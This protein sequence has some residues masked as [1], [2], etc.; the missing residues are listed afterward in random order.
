QMTNL[1][2]HEIDIMQ[3]VIGVSGPSAVS[4]S[5]G[6]FAVQDIGETP[7]TQD[8]LFEYPGFTTAYS[9]REASAGRRAGTGLEFFGPK[10]S[11]TISPAGGPE[12]TSVKP[13]PWAEAI[14]E[15]GSSAQQFDLHARNFLD[16][17]K[18]RQRPIADV[19]GGHQTTTAC[20]LANLSLRLGRKLKWDP[21]KEEILGDREASAM[22]ER[23]YRKPWDTVLRG[24]LS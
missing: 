11:M 1:G 6:R 23:P 20:H 21:V 19:E 17:V 12:R 22:L 24:L 3:W 18:S 15:P 4:S 7:D 9:F 14:K 8:A 16:C 5:G 13:E 10:G 2:A